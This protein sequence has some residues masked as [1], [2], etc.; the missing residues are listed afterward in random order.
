MTFLGDTNVLS[1]LAKRAPDPGVRL[2]ASRVSDLAV[3]VVTVEEIHFGLAWKPNSRIRSWL[4]AFLRRSC[5]ILPVSAEI[6][7]LAGELRG[8][9]RARGR[10]HTQADMLIAATAFVHRLTVVTRNVGHFSDCGI[11]VLNPFSHPSSGGAPAL[12]QP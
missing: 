7:R 9:R 1:E 4:D 2:W 3:S 6:A 12:L 5:S 8:T 10:Q 11:A